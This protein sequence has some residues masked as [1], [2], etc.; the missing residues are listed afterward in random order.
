MSF[1]VFLVLILGR[2]VKSQ[3]DISIIFRWRDKDGLSNAGLHMEDQLKEG[4]ILASP[5]AWAIM[6]PS[7][8]VVLAKANA[9]I[10]RPPSPCSCLH[11]VSRPFADAKIHCI[12]LQACLPRL[13]TWKVSRTRASYRQ[14]V[15]VQRCQPVRRKY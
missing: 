15:E 14:M 8:S 4:A 9:P 5:L 7:D 2:Q 3:R 11:A 13:L 12:F 1:F 10:S 6:I